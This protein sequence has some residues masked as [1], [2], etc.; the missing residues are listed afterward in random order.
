MFAVSNLPGHSQDFRFSNLQ[1]VACRLGVS[2][3][4]RQPDSFAEATKYCRPD[5]KF[6]YP[7]TAALKP[8][9]GDLYGTTNANVAALKVPTTPLTFSGSAGPDTRPE[10]R[11]DRRCRW[12]ACCPFTTACPARPSRR[13]AQPGWAWCSA[14]AKVGYGNALTPPT[15]ATL[16]SGYTFSGDLGAGNFTDRG[17]TFTLKQ[18][19]LVAVENTVSDTAGAATAKIPLFEKQA[20][21]AITLSAGDFHYALTGELS[22]DFGKSDLSAGGGAWVE[23][24][25]LLDLQITA[26]S[27]DLKELSTLKAGSRAAASLPAPPS[28]S[29]P[30]PTAAA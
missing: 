13:K 30:A 1:R 21:V 8:D 10:R 19:S 22:R 28:G 5:P 17:W 12:R 3:G 24:G 6:T 25:K 26:S 2:F 18:L 15:T 14:S 27:W 29:F 9:S 4:A 20:D 16:S 11:A 23:R 7:I